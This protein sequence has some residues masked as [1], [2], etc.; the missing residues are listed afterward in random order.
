[1]VGA[2]VLS[3]YGL[4][5]WGWY[6]AYV[7]ARIGTPPE[8]QLHNARLHGNLMFCLLLAGQLAVVAAA[9][10]L[11]RQYARSRPRGAAMWA[12]AATAIGIDCAV[13]VLLFVYQSYAFQH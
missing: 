3:W 11:F 1:M 6:A 2:S 13:F 7:S 9:G 4:V 5:S 12:S 8:A 10:F